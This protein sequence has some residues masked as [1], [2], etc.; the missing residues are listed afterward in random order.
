MITKDNKDKAIKRLQRSKGDV[1]SPEVQISVLTDRIKEVT[2]HLKANKHDFM[3]RR[4]LM[5]MVGRRKRLLKYLEKTDFEGY[6]NTLEKL[7][8]RK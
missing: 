2:E 8:L 1:G 7:G 6:K 4:G 5:Q 3:A